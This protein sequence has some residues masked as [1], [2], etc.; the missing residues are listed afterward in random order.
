MK[1]SQLSLRNSH[2]SAFPLGFP[3]TAPKTDTVSCDRTSSVS[4]RCKTS[5]MSSGSGMRVREMSSRTF[6]SC[7]SVL[8]CNSQSLS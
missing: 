6:S 1:V 7:E 4:E 5:L 2:T 8:R 3:D